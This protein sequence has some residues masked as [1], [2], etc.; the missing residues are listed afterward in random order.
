[1]RTENAINKCLV[2]Q[3]AI[4]NLDNIDLRIK[5][6]G[7]SFIVQIRNCKITTNIMTILND[8]IFMI[9]NYCPSIV[10]DKGVNGVDNIIQLALLVGT[11]LEDFNQFKKEY[12]TWKHYEIN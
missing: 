4:N 7:G 11:N 10:D 6:Y 12:R 2:L 9:Q 1:M 8:K 5:K 3:Y